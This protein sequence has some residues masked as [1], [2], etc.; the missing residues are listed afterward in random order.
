MSEFVIHREILRKC[1][2]DLDNAVKSRTTEQSPAKD[3]INILEEVTT[4]TIIGSIRVNL[5]TRFNTPWKDSADRNSKENSNNIKYK[6]ADVMRKCHICQS[7]TH[8]DNACPK[9]GK[10]NEIDIEKEP[11]V[12][13]DEVNEYNSDDK[14]SIVSESSK[15]I[16]N[17]N[18]TFKITE[19]FSDFPQLTNGQLDLSKIQDAQLMKTKP[20][21]GKG[22]TSDQLFPIDDIKFNSAS[23]PIKALGIFGTIVIFPQIN[24]NLRITV[25]LVV[26][27]NCSSTHFIFGNDY[28]I[29]YGIDL[30]NNKD[31]YFTIGDNNCQKFAF[32]PLKRQ[33]TVNKVSPV[34]SEL[35]K[36]KSEQLNE[37]QI[38]LH[39]TEP[40][41]HIDDLASIARPLYKLCDKDTF[42]EMIVDRVKAFDSLRQALTTPPLLL[43]PDFKLPFKLYID[44]SGDGLCPALHQFQTMN[45]KPVE[46]PICFIS[47]QIKP[48]EARYRGSQMDCLCL[49]WSLEKLNYFLEGWVFEVITD[50]TAVKSLLNI[51]TPNRHMLRWKIAI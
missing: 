27:E 26:M 10:M 18:S 20:N 4:R 32:I 38:S 33:I 35:E 42:F 50:C 14:S 34:N 47:R 31:R 37:A 13:N 46:G 30:N 19:S 28:L 49:F 40:L 9:K 51:K 7:T 41:V 8:L 15:E 44:T 16:K 48:T 2:G 6:S 45:D 3:I 12:E 21:R 25:E 43:M 5:K 23:N 39:L 36:F 11:D 24:G 29:M 17:I 1:E 22:Y